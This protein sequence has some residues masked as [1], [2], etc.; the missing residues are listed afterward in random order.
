MGAKK[1]KKEPGLQKRSLPDLHSAW[2]LSDNKIGSTDMTPA[3]P[4]RERL[5]DSL[6]DPIDGPRDPVR[7]GFQL[8]PLTVNLPNLMHESLISLS[9]TGVVNMI[10]W[11]RRSHGGSASPRLACLVE[12]VDVKY[13]RSFPGCSLD[14]D[15]MPSVLLLYD[16]QNRQGR[17]L[18]VAHW[19][20]T[21]W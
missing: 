13:E 18:E 12:L 8:L 20:H 9:I 5:R 15:D 17:I 14:F 19:T 4:S 3:G 7:V 1:P 21:G 10:R 16:C 11:C 6:G 2:Y